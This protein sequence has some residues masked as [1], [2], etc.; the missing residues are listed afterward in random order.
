MTLEVPLSAEVELLRE[1]CRR[2]EAT[3]EE[4]NA[5]IVRL[6]GSR[7][8]AASAPKR[9]KATGPAPSGQDLIDDL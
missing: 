3:P 7:A 6:R 1:K 2:D 5:M 4:L 9:A 8:V